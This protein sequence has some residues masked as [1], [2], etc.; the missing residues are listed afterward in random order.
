[1]A[2]GQQRLQSQAKSLEKAAKS[3]KQQGHN[4]HEQKKAAQKALN[5][6]CTICKA[7]MPD[8]KTYKQ[9]F[10]NKHPK[11]DLPNDLKI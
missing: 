10:V 6:V 8:L 5:H 4:A 9:H 3:K 1:M 2:R 7:Q 11:S